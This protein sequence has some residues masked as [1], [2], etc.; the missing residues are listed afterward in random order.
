MDRDPARPTRALVPRSEQYAALHAALLEEA[1]RGPVV[2]TG[3]AGAGKSVLAAE[4]ARGVIPGPDADPTLVRRFD[5]GVVWVSV[6]NLPIVAKQRELARALGGEDPPLGDD[7]D[8]WRGHL[9][10]LTQG[11]RG[12]VVLDNVR[13][14]ADYLALAVDQPGVRILVTTL[15]RTLP[16]ALGVE[17]V[18]VEQLARTE[19]RTLLAE[20]VDRAEDELP[21][22]AEQALSQLG[23]LALGVAMVGSLAADM[24]ARKGGL[25][26]STVWDGLLRRLQDAQLE[27]VSGALAEY[28]HKDLAAAVRVCVDDLPSGAADRWAEL[29]A[30]PPSTPWPTSALED[31]WAGAGLDDW[32]TIEMLR[33]LDRRS[34]VQQD[35]ASR[36]FLHDVQ[37]AV[38]RQRLQARSAEVHRQLLDRWKERFTAALGLTTEVSFGD[39]VADLAGRVSDDQAWSVLDDGYRFQT[40]AFHL[41]EAGRAKELHELLDRDAGGT[42]A[43]YEV[44]RGRG[45]R[46]QFLPD[47]SRASS[48]LE[49]EAEEAAHLERVLRYSLYEASLRTSAARLQPA[50]LEGLLRHGLVGFDEVSTDLA[51]EPETDSLAAKLGLLAAAFPDRADEIVALVSGLQ[52]PAVRRTALVHLAEP[53]GQDGPTHLLTLARDLPDAGSR[54]RALAAL[55]SAAPRSQERAELADEALAALDDSEDPE[56]TCDTVTALRPVASREGLQELARRHLAAASQISNSLTRSAQLGEA[57]AALLRAGLVEEAFTSLRQGYTGP[58]LVIKNWIMDRVLPEMP[59]D[60]LHRIRDRA[61]DVDNED[62]DDLRL[63]ALM[64]P[65]LDPSE[66]LESFAWLLGRLETLEV[67]QRGAILE[68]LV[69]N[70]PLSELPRLL[71]VAGA[72]TESTKIVLCAR[73]CELG[74]FDAALDVAGS[75]DSASG[76]VLC[77]AVLAAGQHPARPSLVER[78]LGRLE[79]MAEPAPDRVLN[80]LVPLLDVDQTARLAHLLSTREDGDRELYLLLRS[81]LARPGAQDG[82]VAEEA[83][84]RAARAADENGPIPLAVCVAVSLLATSGCLRARP[85]A[86]V[87]V[88]AMADTPDAQFWRIPVQ[89]RPTIPPDR[90]A[91]TVATIIGLADK[92]AV[93]VGLEAVAPALLCRR[94]GTGVPV[95]SQVAERPTD[96]TGRHGSRDR[97]LPAHA[98]GGSP[99]RR[100]DPGRRLGR[101][102][103][104]RR[105]P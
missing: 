52:D 23:D 70:A 80:Q 57:N 37:L 25:D 15:D 51:L 86:A 39:L 10:R 102:T 24:L 12:L 62:R 43:W 69:N 42:N 75:V 65:R 30:G 34:L 18:P 91:D 58:G 94:G 97:P 22:Q 5:D 77:W 100:S 59:L 49:G 101:R 89:L 71:S 19:S 8:A 11:R 21:E 32:D 16:S 20:L 55:A 29:S 4:A 33:T 35:D 31:L 63:L 47:V 72:A 68:P 67:D 3:I 105:G 26:A 38:A 54:A 81:S 66:Q 17:A 13:E 1:P 50:V 83:W 104:G 7:V 28:E 73:L 45:L 78:A 96:G 44:L 48:V 88:P 14:L 60:N 6:G 85:E 61:H 98:A 2:V 79:F 87:V 99:G 74:E 56:L 93:E 103:L 76:N 90:L 36:F 41:V 53:L 92:S 27:R 46:S 64:L 9:Q 84:T 82:E 40:L 95:G